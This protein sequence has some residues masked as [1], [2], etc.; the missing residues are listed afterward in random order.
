MKLITSACLPGK[1]EETAVEDLRRHA[2]VAD[3]RNL[4]QAYDD[5]LSVVP[6]E[7][8]LTKTQGVYLKALKDGAM[9]GQFK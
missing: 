5:D 6:D 8:L 9:P 1:E 4:L 2:A 7:L 3:L